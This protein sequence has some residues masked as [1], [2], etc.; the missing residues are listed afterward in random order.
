[1]AKK[2]VPLFKEDDEQ[3]AKKTAHKVKPKSKKLL[4]G[5]IFAVLVFAILGESLIY[6]SRHKSSEYS[7]PTATATISSPAT[8]GVIGLAKNS[9][10]AINI[11]SDAL[12]VAT[13]KVRADN[14]VSAVTINGQL[15]SSSVAKCNDMVQRN[16][17]AH[18]TPDG[19]QPWTFV[20]AAGYK[21]AK[22]GENLGYGFKSSS[23]VVTGWMN[24]LPHRQN[25]LDKTFTEV[26]FG[27][28]KSNS[29][30][31]FGAQ[32]IVVQHF[33]EPA[34]KYQPKATNAYAPPVPKPYV[35]SVCTKIPIPYKTIY[36]DASYM[37][38]DETSSY[39]GY[40]GFTNSCTADSTG[41]KPTD[42]TIQPI[43]KT[44]L[45]GT[46]PRPVPPTT[47]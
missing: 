32:T 40:E 10:D 45:V 42:Y 1:M 11:T 2:K 16:Y 38:T 36:K 4:L 9:Y 15:S 17:W 30:V 20:D 28:C 47:P 46:K 27:I 12:L 14:G 25:L 8:T 21:Y 7:K 44:V 24:S 34:P 3:Y 35:A 41:Y 18:N 37:Y 19:K 33:G 26:G 22:S 23:D 6:I 43:D 13:N 29:Y 39:G 31:G 5:L